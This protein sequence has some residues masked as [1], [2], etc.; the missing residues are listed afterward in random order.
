MNKFYARFLLESNSHMNH[1]VW[2]LPHSSI[3]ISNYELMYWR[4]EESASYL[5]SSPFSTAAIKA[6]WLNYR[7]LRKFSFNFTSIAIHPLLIIQRKVELTFFKF[8][9]LI[10]IQ[11]TTLYSLE[12]SDMHAVYFKKRMVPVWFSKEISS[13]TT[14]F[15]SSLRTSTFLWDANASIRKY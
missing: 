11:K 10:T 14:L 7:E 3:V 6:V 4:T 15:E 1:Y 9:S 5:V 2:K 13:R 8:F 12:C